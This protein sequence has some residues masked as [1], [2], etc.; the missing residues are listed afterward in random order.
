M[1][2]V[3]LLQ[4]CWTDWGCCCWSYYWGWATE[5]EGWHKV[6]ARLCPNVVIC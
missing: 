3:I 2:A 6:Q 1:S 5:V 4:L